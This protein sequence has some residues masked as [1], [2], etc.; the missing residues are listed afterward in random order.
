M[1]DQACP[2]RSS[3][4]A[5]RAACSTNLRKVHPGQVGHGAAAEP[6][7]VA[8]DLWLASEACSPPAAGNQVKAGS[9]LCVD[10]V[11][12]GLDPFG[13]WE[14]LPWLAREEFAEKAEYARHVE[15]LRDLSSSTLSFHF[16]RNTTVRQPHLPREAGSRVFSTASPVRAATAVGAAFCQSVVPYQILRIGSKRGLPAQLPCRR[17][18]TS[19]GSTFRNRS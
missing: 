5:V 2:T 6:G 9:G 13:G 11:Q 15:V 4:A 3:W 7:P 19:L 8:G 10:S 16:G 1:A 14:N 17:L 18:C 12:N